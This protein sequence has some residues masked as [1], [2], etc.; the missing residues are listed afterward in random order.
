V[1]I[2]RLIL[3]YGTLQLRSIL[4]DAKEKDWIVIWKIA[5]KDRD[6]KET[7]ETRITLLLAQ[8]QWR[9]GRGGGLEL[10]S[11]TPPPK[12]RTF[13]KAEPHPNSVEN[14]FVTT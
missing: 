13:D 1:K 4:G 11:S 10:G 8:T 7:P 9:T 6:S 12:F 14:T 5:F 3:I 2:R